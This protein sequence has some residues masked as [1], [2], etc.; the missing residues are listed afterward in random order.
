M[1]LRSKEGGS[2]G[3]GNFDCDHKMLISISF[4][5]YG[6][7]ITIYK[8]ELT[9]IILPE[10]GKETENPFFLSWQLSS[11]LD[12]AVP[13]YQRQRSSSFQSSSFPFCRSTRSVCLYPLQGKNSF[14]FWR[15]SVSLDLAPGEMYSLIRL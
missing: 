8:I 14:A 9:D 10:F 11:R 6:A 1:S 13:P 3:K 5:Y 15:F 4:A 7:I 12:S 2:E